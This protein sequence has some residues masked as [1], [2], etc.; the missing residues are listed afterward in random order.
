VIIVRVVGAAQVLIG[1]LFIQLVLITG[2]VQVLI[3]VALLIAGGIVTVIWP[4]SRVGR[5]ITLAGAVTVGAWSAFAV[6]FFKVQPPLV[7]LVVIPAAASIVM[8]FLL[9]R[10][11]PPFGAVR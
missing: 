2:P 8:A 5:T 7:Y 1:L 4:R 9:Q 10:R 11:P 3:G 6:F